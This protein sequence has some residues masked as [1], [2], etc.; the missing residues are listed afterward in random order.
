MLIDEQR[1]NDLLEKNINLSMK[2]DELYEDVNFLKSENE[3]YA[4]ELEITLEKLNK[5]SSKKL[6]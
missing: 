1:Y 5:I 3:E 2:V 4:K 6:R